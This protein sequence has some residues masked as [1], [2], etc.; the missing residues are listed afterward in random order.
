MIAENGLKLLLGVAGGLLQFLLALFVAFFFWASGD[1]L[2]G[3]RAP[4]CS[5]SPGRGRS[6]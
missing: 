4:C 6:G 5:G 3:H 2:R 1:R